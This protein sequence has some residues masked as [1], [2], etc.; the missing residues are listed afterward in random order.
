MS[1]II[2]TETETPRTPE[3]LALER[4]H[5]QLGGLF[6]DAMNKLHVYEVVNAGWFWGT[7]TVDAGL[8]RRG[9]VYKVKVWSNSNAAFWFIS[10]AYVYY[11]TLPK[12]EGVVWRTE[13]ELEEYRASLYKEYKAVDASMKS[14]QAA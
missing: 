3:M 2:D 14:L 7:E 9:K 8:V 1:E 6:L 11:R 4:K 10:T 12:K 13:A 5:I